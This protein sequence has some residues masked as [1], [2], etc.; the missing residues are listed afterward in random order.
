MDF[1]VSL[2]RRDVI[3]A[4]GGGL[5]S[6]FLASSVAEAQAPSAAKGGS[7]F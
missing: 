2:L 5:A 6:S 1:D 3:K 4:A 7:E